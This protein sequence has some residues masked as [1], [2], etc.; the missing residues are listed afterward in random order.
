MP[1]F[2]VFIVVNDVPVVS[3]VNECEDPNLNDCSPN[4]KCTNTD[5]YYTCTCNKGEWPL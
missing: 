4:A 2:N 3:D 5:G 1:F